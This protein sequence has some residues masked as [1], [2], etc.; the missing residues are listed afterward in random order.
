M[1]SK[2]YKSVMGE[3]YKIIKIPPIFGLGVKKKKTK[4][5]EYKK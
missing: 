1:D 4:K 2:D 5:K 3:K